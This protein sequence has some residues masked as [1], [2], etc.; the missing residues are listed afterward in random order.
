M[1]PTYQIWLKLHSQLKHGTMQV[2]DGK[3]RWCSSSFCWF[4]LCEAKILNCWSCELQNQ[5]F[6][7]DMRFAHA[8]VF[9]GFTQNM[10]SSLTII[11]TVLYSTLLPRVVGRLE[12]INNICVCV[13][14]TYIFYMF[15]LYSSS[16]ISLPIFSRAMKIPKNAQSGLQGDQWL[17]YD[18]TL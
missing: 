4:C 3:F 1:V 11:Y 12:R 8:W 10:V 15:S 7:F 2:A 18:A 14:S 6:G 9:T 16:H 17:E 5:C 13:T